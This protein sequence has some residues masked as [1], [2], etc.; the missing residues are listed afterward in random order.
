MIPGGIVNIINYVFTAT[1]PKCDLM[2]VCGIIRFYLLHSGSDV[3]SYICQDTSTGAV[4]TCGMRVTTNI[5]VCIL[6]LGLLHQGNM[7]FLFTEQVCY[8]Y[9]LLRYSR[10]V[11]LKYV[12]RVLLLFLF[13]LFLSRTRRFF[14]SS[15]LLQISFTLSYLSIA[16]ARVSSSS[17][18][19][20]HF[21]RGIWARHHTRLGH[22]GCDTTTFS[23]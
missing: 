3:I 23:I 17:L 16:R 10:Y 15:V 2:K 5:G 1:E 8:F 12:E 13:S 14:M 22:H 18:G 20:A 6:M 21:H 9:F 7:D 19:W 4:V 11:D